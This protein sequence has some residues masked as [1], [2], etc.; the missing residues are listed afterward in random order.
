MWPEYSWITLLIRFKEDSVKCSIWCLS[1]Y[2]GYWY[3]LSVYGWASRQEI[4]IEIK[5]NSGSTIF[6]FCSLFPCSHL[7][8]AYFPYQA[9]LHIWTS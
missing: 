6:C 3:W 4:N 5:I 8:T 9:L 2:K 1:S 7:Y